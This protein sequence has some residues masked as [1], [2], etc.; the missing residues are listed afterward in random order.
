MSSKPIRIEPAK[1]EVKVNQN[2][3]SNQSEVVQV[4]ELVQN[5]QQD[6]LIEEEK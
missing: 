1:A 5:A 3:L 2:Q 6:N 4:A